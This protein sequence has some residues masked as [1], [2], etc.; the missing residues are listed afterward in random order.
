MV[1]VRRQRLPKDSVLNL[2]SELQVS[3]A[4]PFSLCVQQNQNPKTNKQ[5]KNKQIHE[6]KQK[7]PTLHDSF[8]S[9]SQEFDTVLVYIII[10]SFK[11][12]C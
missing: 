5:K 9:M 12:I 8:V 4:Q 11:Q 1:R 3:V 6:T 2:S 7:H 10:I